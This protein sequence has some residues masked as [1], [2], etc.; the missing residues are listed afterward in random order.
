M[1]R[2]KKPLIQQENSDENLVEEV[3]ERE[4]STYNTD[5]DHNFNEN[6]MEEV[7]EVLHYIGYPELQQLFYHEKID[8]EVL[9]N[10]NQNAIMMLLR[11]Y[12]IG[13]RIKFYFKLRTF[14]ESIQ[15]NQYNIGSFPSSKS[16]SSNVS[17]LNDKLVLDDRS[18]FN[19]LNETDEGKR[20]IRKHPFNKALN[21]KAKAELSGIICGVVLNE[22]LKIGRKEAKLLSESICA[23][24]EKEDPKSYFDGKI[25][26][27]YSKAVYLGNKLKD[28]IV[29]EPAKKKQ[30]LLSVTEMEFSVEEVN[31][32]DF[33][34]SN[35][36]STLNELMFHWDLG[37]RK[38]SH[39]MKSH[40][41]CNL[42]DIINVYKSYSRSDGYFLVDSDFNSLCPN[43]LFEENW[44]RLKTQLSKVLSKNIANQRI[45]S[46]LDMIDDMSEESKSI[47]VLYG[48]HGFLY[49][50]SNTHIRET[51]EDSFE[52]MI[53]II[54]SEGSLKI[55]LQSLREK[56]QLK[57]QTLQPVIFCI[58]DDIESIINNRFMLIF[59]DFMYTFTDFCTTFKT[60]LQM[61]VV[62]NLCYPACSKNVH[63]FIASNLLDQKCELAPKCRS[64]E[65]LISD[66][67]MSNEL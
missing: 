23:I 49:S 43:V 64:L 44:S 60:Y 21:V 48:L 47:T 24:Y 6:G 61:F 39:F 45:I 2:A 51:I 53:S 33:V 30:R 38:R 55:K 63:E 59:D 65:K 57:K 19:I 54:P 56:I 46:K 13:I 62:F 9:A 29:D 58:G 37:F 1:Y 12:P 14:L 16:L 8:N 15:G 5:L 3:I 41:D 36:H 17:S 7:N 67:L 20:F 28:K 26:V 40:N 18:V 31:S 10:L 52:Q 22:G 4:G 34:R 50:R 42:K 11:E 66:E 25:G 27:L 35:P 32:D